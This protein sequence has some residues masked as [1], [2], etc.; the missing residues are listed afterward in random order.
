MFTAA[1]DASGSAENR[2]VAPDGAWDE[3]SKEWKERLAQDLHFKAVKS[4]QVT[5]ASQLNFVA[6]DTTLG[7]R[8]RASRTTTTRKA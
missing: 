7:S 5:G 8:W 6:L 1:L 3:F 2:L 4:V